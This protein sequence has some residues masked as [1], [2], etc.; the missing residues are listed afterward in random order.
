MERPLCASNSRKTW[1]IR[2]FFR[3]AL[4]TMATAPVSL[5]P[6]LVG[7]PPAR[8]AWK[9]SRSNNNN[10][11]WHHQCG[12][13]SLV[14]PE[15]DAWRMCPWA[16]LPTS[17]NPPRKW[18]VNQM[19][20]FPASH[21]HRPRVLPSSDQATRDPPVL[22]I[23]TWT[24]NHP[25]EVRAQY[26]PVSSDRMCTRTTP[27]M[28]PLKKPNCRMTWWFLRGLRNDLRPG[29]VIIRN[30][31]HHLHS[32]PWAPWPRARRI[33]LMEHRTFSRAFKNPPPS[34][35]PRPPCLRP[36]TTILGPRA[37]FA[38]RPLTGDNP[39]VELPA[40]RTET[41]WIF[42]IWNA[43][44][45]PLPW[46][47]KSWRMPTPRRIR[48]KRTK[49]YPWVDRLD[50]L[51]TTPWMIRHR[52]YNILRRWRAILGTLREV[53][54][55]MWSWE[56]MMIWMPI[57]KCPRCRILA[58]PIRPCWIICQSYCKF[59]CRTVD[60]L[61]RGNDWLIVS[62]HDDT[63][64]GECVFSDCQRLAID[65]PVLFV[66]RKVYVIHVVFVVKVKKK[67]KKIIVARKLLL[68]TRW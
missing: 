42:R 10:S 48:K 21:R 39:L 3:Q 16:P 24:S 9:S 58:K 47:T 20:T 29:T 14:W 33:R 64:M 23:S 62:C 54:W 25:R 15:G 61:T 26:R 68:W 7:L 4:R 34:S 56:M 32:S 43:T 19:W 59:H 60:P 66:C 2:T 13:W 40:T 11:T 37:T 63:I 6:S 46:K 12:Q 36:R 22:R 30:N 53:R 55:T 18:R 67:K 38:I 45:M 41:W 50:L 44:L 8:V 5:L 49:N 52:I 27:W 31:N 17:R 65:A 35:H 57:T 28:I 51:I 1:G